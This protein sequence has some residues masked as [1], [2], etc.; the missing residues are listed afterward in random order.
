MA[1]TE[2]SNNELWP[3]VINSRNV[4]YINL[5]KNNL[6]YI[7]LTWRNVTWPRK[8]K[9]HQYLSKVRNSVLVLGSFKKSN[10]TSIQ[11]KPDNIE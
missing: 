2:I 5:A 9:F 11:V 10:I 3:Y 7:N 8:I 4:R 6:T 1:V